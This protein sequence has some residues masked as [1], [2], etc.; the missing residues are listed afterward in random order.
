MDVAITRPAMIQ[1]RRGKAALILALALAG[2]T[3]VFQARSMAEVHTFDPQ[4]RLTD[5][6][7]DNGGSLHYAYDANG[8]IL[9]VIASLATAAE[10]SESPLQ[11]A[12]GPT[13]PNPGSGARN[14]NF[15]IPSNGRVSLRVFDVAGRVVATLLDRDLSAGRYSARFVTDRWAA[16]VYF[17]RLKL[18]SRT[19]T[20]RMVVLR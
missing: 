6:A 8:N 14:L 10:T 17:Y 2:V 13:T 9:S 16:G 19:R 11:F 20:G 4:G 1:T 3:F 15:S 5:I 18:G 7:Y 12:L